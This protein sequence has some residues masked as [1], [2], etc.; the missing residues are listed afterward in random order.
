MIADLLLGLAKANLAAAAAILVVILLRK[1]SRRLF[2]AEAAYR[3]WLLVP[4]AS[5]AV[6]APARS[7]TAPPVIPI[8][9]SPVAVAP[10]LAPP[11]QVQTPPPIAVAR[12]SAPVSLPW[13]GAEL[14]L[15][16]WLLG[17]AVSFVIVGRRQGRFVAGLGRLTPYA[18]A[19]V[20]LAESAE[21]GPA[22]VGALAPRIVAPADFETRFT[23]EERQVVLAH[24]RAH[25][26]RQDARANGL[27]A[28]AQCLNWF[29][30]LVHLAGYLV[31]LDQELACDA[32]VIAKLP[33]QRRRYAEAL[34][35]SQIA[36]RPLPLGCYWPARAGHPLEERIAMLKQPAPGAGRRLAGLATI[37]TLGMFASV[38]AWASQP[39][40]F[41]PSPAIAPVAA[42]PAHVTAPAT[43]PPPQAVSDPAIGDWIGALKTPDLRIA[44]H[45]RPGDG[46]DHAS[47]DSPDQGAYDLEV[48]SVT[49]KDGK[50]ALELPKLKASY[51]ATWDAAGHRWVGTWTQLGKPWPLVLTA[52]SYPP[53]A[54]IAG[55]DGDW[56][57][58]LQA[59]SAIRLTVRV[60]TDARGTRGSLDSP[61]QNAFGL[62][63]SS[64]TRDGDHVTF[65]LKAIDMT[66]AGDLTNGGQVINATFTQNGATLPLALTRNSAAAA[67]APTP[68]SAAASTADISGTWVF[69][70]V[71]VNQGQ[72][73]AVAKPVC[74]F[75]QEGG[76]LVG[77]CKGP[78]GLGPASGAVDGQ[79]VSW[80]WDDTAFTPAGFSGVVSFDGVLGADN[81][82]R[83]SMSF[84]SQPSASGTF[85]GR[86][87]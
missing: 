56:S 18:E 31:R 29:N 41:A 72:V 34:L 69:E 12:P 59:G 62:P 70:G 33:G 42:A 48:S 85:S 54:K 49:S 82:I 28:L 15:A 27:V 51:A 79:K 63:L 80:K 24:E 16:L 64:V 8:A 78:N 73:A 23:P 50:L 11:V 14:A 46:A 77:S 55:L 65:T 17:A 20:S 44:L 58:K 53:T 86:R 47:L 52:G 67:A 30:P 37:L 60:F 3:L 76:R 22:V 45:I 84:S 38:A 5:L 6:L 43:P 10:R 87:Q 2:G 81:M 71:L 61:D 9:A 68:A 39:P 21:I 19:D 13:S 1:A 75:Q 57:G 7:V 36:A 83:G 35:K 40:R 74:V 25:L 66:I 26:A 32:A 4:L